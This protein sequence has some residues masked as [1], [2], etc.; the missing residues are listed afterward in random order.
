MNCVIKVMNIMKQMFLIA[1]FF[2]SVGSTSFKEAEHQLLATSMRITVLDNLGNVVENAQVTIYGNRGDYE[3]EENSVAGPETTD[4]KGRVTFKKLDEKSYYVRVKKGDKSNYNE[5]EKTGV[6]LRG[7][8][9][10]FNIIIS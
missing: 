6:L 1:L 4:A 7:K 5:G 10:K 3:N 9:N 8:L 2:I